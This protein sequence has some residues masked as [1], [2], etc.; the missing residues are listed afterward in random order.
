MAPNAKTKKNFSFFNKLVREK[1]SKT[2]D[3]IVDNQMRET[4]ANSQLI[5]KL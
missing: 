2:A 4:I 1:V 3:E 5:K